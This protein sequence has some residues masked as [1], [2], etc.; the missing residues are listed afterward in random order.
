MLE[1]KQLWGDGGAITFI[2]LEFHGISLNGALD[3]WEASGAE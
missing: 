1:E 3:G 2:S